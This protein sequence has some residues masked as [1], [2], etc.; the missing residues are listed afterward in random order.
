[1]IN[2]KKLIMQADGETIILPIEQAIA[3]PREDVMFG[4]IRGMFV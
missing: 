2:P 4:G 1:M 3:V